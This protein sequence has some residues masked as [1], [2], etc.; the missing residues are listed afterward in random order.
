VVGLDREIIFNSKIFVHKV[1]GSIGLV[2]S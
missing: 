1:G 2:S